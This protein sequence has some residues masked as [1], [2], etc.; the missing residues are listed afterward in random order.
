M[1]LELFEMA[2]EKGFWVSGQYVPLCRTLYTTAITLSPCWRYKTT[3]WL[4]KNSAK[5]TIDG[6]T[7]S[8]GSESDLI[9]TFNDKWNKK[10]SS[11]TSFSHRPALVLFPLCLSPGTRAPWSCVSLQLRREH[12]DEKNKR[13]WWWWYISR[14]TRRRRYENCCFPCQSIFRKLTHTHRERIRLGF[15][16]RAPCWVSRW[17]SFRLVTFRRIKLPCIND[18][19]LC[20]CCCK[21]LK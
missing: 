10:T 4:H 7:L 3:T 5:V 14:A 13:W 6:K 15:S 11:M 20:T 8:G 21:K 9:M 19:C 16:K 18:N 12:D 1:K 2:L 17:L